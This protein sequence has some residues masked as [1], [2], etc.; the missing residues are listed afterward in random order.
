VALDK[1]GKIFCASF[2]ALLDMSSVFA[3]FG[4]PESFSL[5]FISFLVLLN[6]FSLWAL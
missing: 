3:L 5:V 4:F 1:S 2:I 6:L